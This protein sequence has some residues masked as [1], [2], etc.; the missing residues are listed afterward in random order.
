MWS[1]RSTEIDV[2]SPSTQ[3]FGRC[4]QDASTWNI[5]TLSGLAD[6]AC[7]AATKADATASVTANRQTIIS[8]HLVQAFA[9]FDAR[10][11]R[12]GDEGDGDAERLDF[13]VGDRRL[14]P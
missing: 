5:G 3:L 2:T 1:L 7:P 8:I 6:C 10:A 14:D 13:P 12:V 11:P 9:E 4:G